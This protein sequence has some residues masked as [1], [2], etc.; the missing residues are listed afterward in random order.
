MVNLKEMV[1]VYFLPALC[2]QRDLKH[3]CL[4]VEAVFLEIRDDP[5]SVVLKQ[6][7]KFPL[8]GDK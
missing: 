3:V 7:V 5:R 4:S 2:L 6:R 1:Q 8:G